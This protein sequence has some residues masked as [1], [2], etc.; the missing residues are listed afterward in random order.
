MTLANSI[1]PVVDR[2]QTALDRQLFPSE[3]QQW[4]ARLLDHLKKPVQVA[5]MGLP[6]SGKSTLI[7][8]MLPKA[9]IPPLPGVPVVELAYGPK[10]RTTFEM[11]DGQYVRRSGAQG[12]TDVPEGAVRARVELA[13]DEL[14]RQNF[15]EVGLTGG[16]GH[17]MSLV[18]WVAQWADIVLWCTE[19]FE[20]TEQKLWSGVPEDIKDHSFLVLTMA[21]RQMMR[22]HLQQRI[23]ALEPLV[24]EEFLGL[25]PVAT[26]QAI[27]ARTSGPQVNAGLWKS[28]GGKEL[29]EGVM[30]QV[31]NGRTA[32][33]DQAQMLLNKF[34]PQIDAAMRKAQSAAANAPA[35]VVAE[36]EV[37]MPVVGEV[38]EV[39]A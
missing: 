11:A 34:A 33:M 14:N 21:D 22:G 26:I 20:A 6:G 38:T 31:D 2:L 19:A 24:A 23:R 1:E 3:W 16:A 4:G 12:A 39:T 9:A 30:R 35:P 28:S 17:Q 13:L 7:N 27:T 32:D 10:P 18:N 29:F 36:A 25:Y 15:I 37:V 8:M 5:V